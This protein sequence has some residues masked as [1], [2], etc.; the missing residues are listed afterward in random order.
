MRSTAYGA[1]NS[2]VDALVR[3][4]LAEA[5]FSKIVIEF[6][7]LAHDLLDH[8]AVGISCGRIVV[9]STLQLLSGVLMPRDP[10]CNCI[11][12]LSED[13]VEPPP[14]FVGHAFTADVPLRRLRDSSLTVITG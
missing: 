8:H 7:F 9:A 13:H 10:N 12:D 5:S 3:L 1:P 14:A 11:L 2:L 6:S 4:L